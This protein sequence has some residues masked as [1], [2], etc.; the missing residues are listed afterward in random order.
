MLSNRYIARMHTFFKVVFSAFI[1]FAG[2]SAHSQKLQGTFLKRGF[3]DSRSQILTF[4]DG[5]FTD[6]IYQHVTNAYGVGRYKLNLSGSLR[7]LNARFC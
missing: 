5:N 6:T 3:V 1:L 4:N 2:L 7:Y